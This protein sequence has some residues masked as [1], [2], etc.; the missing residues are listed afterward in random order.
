MSI[1]TLISDFGLKDHYVGILKGKIYSQFPEVNIVDLS[2]EVAKFNLFDASYLL[3]VSY[4]HFPKGTVHIMTVDAAQTADTIHIA[5]LLDGHYFIGADNGVLGHLAQ[6]INPEKMVQ[7]NIHDRLSGAAND[8]DVFATVAAHLAK[9][10]ALTVIGKEVEEIKPLYHLHVSVDQELQFIKGHVVYVDDFGNCVTNI[11][12]KQIDDVAKGRKSLV[13][14]HNKKIDSIKKNY[15]DFKKNDTASLKTHEGNA[16]AIINEAGFL[17][18]AIYKSN[19]DSI[20]SA[21]SLLGLRFRDLVT[22]EFES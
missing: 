11:T 16:V 22:V 7:I 9:G 12:K 14:F 1:I 8:L 10:G 6:K 17:E 20:G 4:Y 21:T 5:M 3:E 15:T 2:H 18:I 19:P 13:R